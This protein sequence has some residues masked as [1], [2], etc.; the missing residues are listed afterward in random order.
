M[1]RPSLWAGHSG[2]PGRAMVGSPRDRLCSGPL[3]R[4]LTERIGP[5]RLLLELA[6]ALGGGRR[7]GGGDALRRRG[8]VCRTVRVTDR[9]RDLG[10]VLAEARAGRDRAGDG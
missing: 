4:L 8:A 2:C 5:D 9:G 6:G 3:E 10:L 1:R 7:G